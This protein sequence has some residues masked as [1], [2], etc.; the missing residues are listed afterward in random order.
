MEN[1][2]VQ[3]FER[4]LRDNPK[5]RAFAPLAEAYRK[6]GQ[7]EKALEVAL[8]GVEANSDYQGGK[9]ALSRVLVDLNQIKEAKKN[10]EEVVKVEPD[11]I[12]ALRILGKV[13]IQLK[14]Y[15]KAIEVYTCIKAFQPEDQ[16]S[17]KILLG[18]RRSGALSEASGDDHNGERKVHTT[19]T[20]P[21]NANLDL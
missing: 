16:K 20:P 12:L 14:D 19:Q 11:N 9:V 4:I 2:R 3:H 15:Q 1:L 18:L 21:P 8:K 17:E 7:L 10:L 6:N 13:C 5:S